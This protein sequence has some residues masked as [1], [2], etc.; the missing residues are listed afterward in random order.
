MGGLAFQ[1]ICQDLNGNTPLLTACGGSH[2]KTETMVL[3]L[4]GAR[5]TLGHR[6]LGDKGFNLPVKN[7]WT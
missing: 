2:G 1:F 3:E 5:A 4:L 7:G 6:P